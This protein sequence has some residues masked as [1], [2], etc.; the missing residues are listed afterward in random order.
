VRYEQGLKNRLTGDGFG[1]SFVQV[2]SEQGREGWDLKDVVWETGLQAI[3]I[4]SREIANRPL[5]KVGASVA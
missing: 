2:L 5:A 1:E 4:F 3:F